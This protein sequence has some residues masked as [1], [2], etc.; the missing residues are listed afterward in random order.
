M[1]GFI[2]ILNEQKEFV[3]IYEC[4]KNNI[5]PVRATSTAESQKMHLAFSLCSKLNRPLVFVAADSLTA[6]FA[7]KDFQFFYSENDVLEFPE[8]EFI[9]YDVDAQSNETLKKRLNTLFSLCFERKNF[10]VVTTITALCQK[11]VS[12]DAFISYTLDLKT[13]DVYDIHSIS[14]KLVKL[15]YQR[16]TQVEGAGQFAVRGGIIDIFP[17]EQKNAARI[18]FFDDEIDSIRFFDVSTQLSI[19][20]CDRICITPAGEDFSKREFTLFDYLKDAVYFI[21]EP[22]QCI[23]SYDNFKDD[24]T[25]QIKSALEKDYKLSKKAKNPDYYIEDYNSVIELVSVAGAVGLSN[26]TMSS[27]GLNPKAIVSMQTKSMPTYSGN[28]DLLCDDL[29]FYLIKDYRIILPCGSISRAKHVKDELEKR[30]VVCELC[31]SLDSL[32]ERGKVSLVTGTI[33]HGFE[34][35]LTKTALISDKELSS[36]APPKTKRPIRPKGNIR[37]ISDINEGDFIVHQ[38][39]GIGVYKGIHQLEM[40]GV[41]KDYLKIKYKGS[42]ILYVPVN[43]LNLINKYIGGEENVRVNKLG[44]NEWNNTKSKVRKSL[45]VLAKELVEL[46]AKRQ[47]SK[48]YAFC[49]DGEFQKDFESTFAY[50]ETDDQLKAIKDVKKDMESERPMD[51]LICGDVGYGKTEVAIRA[52]FKAV[53]DSKQVAYLVPTTLLA[54]QHYDNFVRRMKGFPVQIE[55]LS[56]FRNKKQQQESIERLKKGTADIVIGTHRIIQDDVKFKDLGLLIIDEEQRFGVKHKEKIKQMKHNVDVLTLSATPIPRTLNMAMSGLRDM[57]VLS[58]PPE[59]RHPVQ[60]YVT[61]FNPQVIKTAITREIARGGQVYYLHNFTDSIES[62]AA[63]LKNL[64]PE[65]RIAVAHG[66]MT[67]L[68]LENVM[69]SVLNGEYDILVCTTIIETGLDIPN[70]NTIIVENADR[71]GLSQLYQLRGRVGRSS[72]LAYA[73]LTVRRDKVLDRIAEKRLKAIKE[74]TEFGAGIKIAMRDLEIRGAGSVLGTHQHGHMNQVGYELY[75]KL[76]SEAVNQVK[77]NEE[78]RE[79]VPVTID[80]NISAFI[81][82][83][84]ISDSL[85]RI[86][87]YKVISSIENEDDALSVTDELLDRFSDPPQS[88][89]NLIDTVLIRNL[90]KE[91][92]ISDIQQKGDSVVMKLTPNSPMQKL[93]DYVSAHRIEFYFSALKGSTCLIYKPKDK[94]QKDLAKNLKGILKEI[95]DKEYND[96]E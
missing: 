32:P 17:F 86:D 72:R 51:R 9:F 19:E 96:K 88:V 4:L 13:G 25:E 26:L 40:D 18:E 11:I 93:A 2:D 34:Y 44:G 79:E 36:E 57:S 16:E 20:K 3:E 85:T 24:L 14:E 6:S 82:E 95:K 73:Y 64:V 91:L 23:Q 35:P 67:E 10:C 5:S 90:A 42:D 21:D 75:C 1:Q 38:V 54:Q 15:G 87:I 50:V 74:F 71:F 81:P 47:A 41:I 46:Y 39:H 58:E 68:Q 61:E 70:M 56:R 65:A 22:H 80:I 78:I 83:S 49:A 28:F 69:L 37:S 31:E 76:L 53:S 30:N 66:K 12:K 55:L 92:S 33:K 29:L 63:K 45:E 94:P 43:Q 89:I 52:A 59:D 62:T 48:G 77:N 7:Y 60:T 8:R 84:Y 27:K